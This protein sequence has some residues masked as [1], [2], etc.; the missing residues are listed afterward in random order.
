MSEPVFVAFATQKGGAGKS[1]LTALTASCLHYLDGIEVMV[2]DCDDRQH[3]FKDYRD[4]DLVVTEEN[5]YLKR[6]MFNF[7]KKFKGKPYEILLTN[8]AEAAQVAVDRLEEGADPKVVFFDITGTINDPAIVRL[9]AVM[10]YLF[11]P[12]STDTA[13]MKSSIRFASHV[14]NQM[15]TT[16]QTKI[17]S[18]NLV[19][20]R[21]PS[22]AKTTL[23]DL[24]DKYMEELG[25]HSLDTV[26]SSSARFFKD[27]AVSGKT[28]L[29]RST[30]MP[31]DRQLL[32]GSNLPELVREIRETIKV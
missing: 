29:F 23:C 13:D 7:Y 25:L 21:I 2:V 28:G 9:L 22:K 10:D 19:W 20:N 26:L 30:M 12:I 6:A 5:P 18:V 8:P 27:G 14:V 15:V 17:K 1:T 31:P 3:S 24:I 11:V 16:G 32:K 4:K